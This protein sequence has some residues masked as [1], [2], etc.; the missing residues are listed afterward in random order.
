MRRAEAGR[1]AALGVMLLLPAGGILLLFWALIGPAT[2]VVA[3]VAAL[4]YGVAKIDNH[5]GSCLM[6]TLLA[7]IVV[8]IMAGLMALLAMVGMH[9]G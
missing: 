3:A 1:R 8:A 7:L 9:P 6:V 2:L 5:T 4:L